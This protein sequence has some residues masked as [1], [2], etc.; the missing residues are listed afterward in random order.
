MK[1]YRVSYSQEGGNS[2]GFSW[3]TSYKAALAAARADY[4]ENPAEYDHHASRAAL[5]ERIE[6]IHVT[7]TRRGILGALRAYVSHPDNG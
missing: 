2:G 5:A 3:H 4:N 7:P 6:P 1:F